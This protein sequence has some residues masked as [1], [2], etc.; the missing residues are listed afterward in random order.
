MK[1][2]VVG[3]IVTAT[4]LLVGCGGGSGSNSTK[5]NTLATDATSPV[6][7]LVDNS[8]VNTE[9]IG[10][11]YYIDNAVE[12][13]NYKCGNQEGVTDE[14][15][16]FSFESGQNCTFVLGDLQLRE[17]NASS[18]EDNVS[19]L[20]DNTTVAQ[21]LQ[22]LDS[23]GN[24]SNGIQIPQGAGQVIRDELTSLDKPLDKDLLT[25]IHDAIKA[26]E[27]HEYNGRVVDI[28]ETQRHLDETRQRLEQEG[29]RTQHDVEAEHRARGGFV[30]NNGSRL[31]IGDGQEHQQ[32]NFID[33]NRSNSNMSGNET[34]QRDGFRDDNRGRLDVGDTQEHQQANFIDNNR[35][36]S[37]ADTDTDNSQQN[38]DT[39]HSSTTSRGEV[40]SSNQN[41][42]ASSSSHGGF[43]G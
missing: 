29:R 30:D 35:M 20:E 14:N 23:D 38:N 1:K 11:G 7:T 27:Q 4:L 8:S 31:D 32:G 24:A 34:A 43:R 6:N 28:N 40:S 13:V 19:I 26:D 36:N 15:G 3:S 17:V 42:N 33:N 37:N 5:D 21:L 18:L 9:K 2:L 12:G 10:K 41:G 39:S 16:T 22:T 25:A